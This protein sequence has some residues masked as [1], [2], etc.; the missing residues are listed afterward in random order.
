[1]SLFRDTRD[2]IILVCRFRL[3]H[4]YNI[5][6]SSIQWNNLYC[7]PEVCTVGTTC[8]IKVS[9]LYTYNSQ[10]GWCKHEHKLK[11]VISLIITFNTHF[12]L[13]TR[14]DIIN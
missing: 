12:M 3:F 5:L 10:L 9:F 7:D 4:L 8:I 6:V 11:T 1:M 14:S 2:V 13:L